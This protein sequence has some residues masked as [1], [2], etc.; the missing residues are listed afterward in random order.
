MH[1]F[2]L[3]LV[4]WYPS[5]LAPFLSS[6]L[7]HG[8]VCLSLYSVMMHMILNLLELADLLFF[9]EVVNIEHRLLLVVVYFLH[10]DSGQWGGGGRGEPHVVLGCCG[11]RG[12]LLEGAVHWRSLVDGISWSDCVCCHVVD[13]ERVHYWHWDYVHCLGCWRSIHVI[14][15]FQLYLLEVSFLL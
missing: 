12:F 7:Q 14:Y 2:F 11:L 6:V 10:A 15:G 5:A 3:L 1:T 8:L 13:L 4:R 9:R